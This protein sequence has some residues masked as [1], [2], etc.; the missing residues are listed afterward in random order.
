MVDILLVYMM[1]IENEL[2]LRKRQRKDE[3]GH[4]RFLFVGR[5]RKLGRGRIAY[6]SIS[7][8]LF[9]K[10][11]RDNFI[12]R[13]QSQVKVREKS[14]CWVWLGQKPCACMLFDLE[15]F[16]QKHTTLNAFSKLTSYM[17]KV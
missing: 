3:G 4:F 2:L 6:L 1:Y 5:K 17:Y 7:C 10:L 15:R 12:G 9:I 13:F 11:T 16:L 14:F 8:T